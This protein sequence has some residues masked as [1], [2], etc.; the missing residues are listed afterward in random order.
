MDDDHVLVRH[1]LQLRRVTL[2]QACSSIAAVMALHSF[3]NT[4]PPLHGWVL[5]AAYFHV[6]LYAIL[7]V[8]STLLMSTK[9][10]T[11]S[12]CRVA[13]TL[14]HALFS[15]PLSPGAALVVVHRAVGAQSDSRS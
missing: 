9:T 1:L 7:V 10:S 13:S 5:F 2:T 6:Y 14:N 8:T 11:A 4:M 15:I 3:P 12:L